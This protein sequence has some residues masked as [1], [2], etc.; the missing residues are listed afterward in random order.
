MIKSPKHLDLRSFSIDDDEHPVKYITEKLT[1]GIAVSI[2]EWLVTEIADG[3]P[4]LMMP[5]P[6]EVDIPEPHPNS[7]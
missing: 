3:D 4:T 2:Y 7:L 1:D 5:N 6:C